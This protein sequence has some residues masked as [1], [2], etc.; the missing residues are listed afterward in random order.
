MPLQ[1]PVRAHRCA[2]QFVAAGIN[3]AAPPC[4]NGL[5]DAARVAANHV[6][7]GHPQRGVLGFHAHRLDDDQIAEPLLQRAL[8]EELR[9]RRQHV[10][11]GREHEL[12]QAAAEVRP[13][14]PLAGA[15]NST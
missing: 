13:H 6:L 5:G 2:P 4:A 15:V 11:V 1:R 9:G 10:A 14:D 3:H 12:Q 7:H 8:H